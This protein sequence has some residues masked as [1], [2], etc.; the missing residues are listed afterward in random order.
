[1]FMKSGPVSGPIVAPICLLS[2]RMINVTKRQWNIYDNWSTILMC[3]PNVVKMSI[4][5][6]ET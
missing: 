4:V 6:D 5:A 2:W 1:M 3:W